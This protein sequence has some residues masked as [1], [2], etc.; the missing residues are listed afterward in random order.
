[1]QFDHHKY[2]KLGNYERILCEIK[3]RHVPPGGRE[4]ICYR[5]FAQKLAM[6]RTPYELGWKLQVIMNEKRKY[7]RYD[8][9]EELCGPPRDCLRDKRESNHTNSFIESLIH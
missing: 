2:L 9:L 5:G 4:G 1:M 7:P 8:Q 6:G 3:Q